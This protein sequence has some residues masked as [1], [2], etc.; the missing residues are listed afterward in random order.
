M[1]SIYQFNSG[2]LGTLLRAHSPLE[3]PTLDIQNLDQAY[4][5]VKAYGFDLKDDHDREKLWDYYRRAL[6]F[7]Q[8]ELL[9]AGEKVPAL[10]SEPGQLKDLAYL[11]I[12]AS[13]EDSR[14]ESLKAWSCAILRV[15]HVLCHVDNDLFT[16]YSKQ[17]QDQILKPFQDAIFDDPV[18]GPQLGGPMEPERIP[19]KKFEVKAFKSSDSSI[20]KLLAKREA[21][22]FGILDKVGVRF[23]TKSQFD[24]FRVI[25]YL[26]D[27][28]LVS[29]PHVV[30]GQAHNN[31]Y[32]F[33]LFLEVMETL[34]SDRT[35]PSEEIDKL[36]RDKLMSDANRA[37]FLEKPNLFSS[38]EYRFIKF[39]SRRLVRVKSGD[40]VISFFYPF[41]VQLIDYHT[42][43][44][45]LA[46]P[47]AHEEYKN[48][49]RQRARY[50]ILG[51]PK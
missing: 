43:M 41:E 13:T 38:R 46:G 35:M 30:M 34:P 51:D 50:R 11:L 39:I 4:E 10:L 44:Q 33:N 48:R 49:Q 47:S 20:L 42:H 3:I 28:S 6:S 17:I 1:A 24:V 18:S 36:L 16:V 7:I 2:I 29:F 19:L 21:I 22:A 37:E 12:Y 27:K 14:P 25:R 45:N 32:P 40:Q 23:I 5:F 8:S 26:V 15:I 31:L 9:S